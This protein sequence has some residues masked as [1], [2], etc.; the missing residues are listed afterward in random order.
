MASLNVIWNAGLAFVSLAFCKC[1][2][3]GTAPRFPWDIF[4]SPRWLGAW[5]WE[6]EEW[7]RWR[8]EERRPNWVPFQDRV[9]ARSMRGLCYSLPVVSGVRFA[10]SHQLWLIKSFSFVAL[11]L[12]LFSKSS[13]RSWG[14]RADLSVGRSPGH[15]WPPS[16]PQLASIFLPSPI[17]T[18]ELCDPMCC[19]WSPNERYRTSSFLGLFQVVTVRARGRKKGEPRLHAQGQVQVMEGLGVWLE[20]CSRRGQSL[21]LFLVRGLHVVS[22]KLGH[23]HT[24]LSSLPLSPPLLGK[25]KLSYLV[26]L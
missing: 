1:R 22:Q 15:H 6:R 4:T 23:F 17:G 25:R 2:L 11:A 19:N 18:C 16:V 24:S 9:W 12:H 14:G 26:S 5:Y 7:Q 21:A 8:G 10:W 20:Y 3:V 13:A